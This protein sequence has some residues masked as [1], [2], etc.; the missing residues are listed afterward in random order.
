MGAQPQLILSVD[1]CLLAIEAGSQGGPGPQNGT[2]RR[3]VR[4]GKARFAFAVDLL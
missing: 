2:L 3:N 1:L 4:K